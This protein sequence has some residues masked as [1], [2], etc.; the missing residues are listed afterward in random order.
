VAGQP[1][2]SP[3]PGMGGAQGAGVL[4][5][6][7]PLFARGEVLALLGLAGNLKVHILNVTFSS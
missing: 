2:A 7:I 1:V 4:I 6:C 3:T 5:G